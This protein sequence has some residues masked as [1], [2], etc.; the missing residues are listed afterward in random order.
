[1]KTFRKFAKFIKL[2]Q[3]FDEQTFGHSEEQAHRR[4][5][6]RKLYTPTS[7]FVCRLYNNYINRYWLND[8]YNTILIFSHDFHFHNFHND[9]EFCHVMRKCSNQS[10]HTQFR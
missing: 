10:V 5:E 1:M 8:N 4:T 9:Y 3:N 6:L 2:A 7:Y